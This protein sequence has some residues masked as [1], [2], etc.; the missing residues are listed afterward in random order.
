M[1]TAGWFVRAW[2]EMLFWLQRS[3]MVECSFGSRRTIVY[4]YFEGVLGIGSLFESEYLEPL[5]RV[6][7]FLNDYESTMIL[8]E[9]TGNCLVECYT[10]NVAV[11]S[12]H[13]FE[14][15]RKASM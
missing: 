9:S 2:L 6:D 7:T 10:L 13:F 8:F 11:Q 5:L 14:Y 3:R 12:C 1:P 15:S 4:L